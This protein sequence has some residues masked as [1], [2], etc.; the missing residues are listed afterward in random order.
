[1]GSFCEQ[2]LRGSV[3]CGFPLYVAT[4]PPTPNTHT[5]THTNRQAT[6]GQKRIPIFGS[7]HCVSELPK[8]HKPLVQSRSNHPQF[9][10]RS[11]LLQRGGIRVQSK[12][13]SANFI[14]VFNCAHNT[15]PPVSPSL[16]V[17]APSLGNT[18]LACLGSLGKWGR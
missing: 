12:S 9:P 3:N 16:G 2:Q 15:H 18:I 5:H 1:M 17:Q 7:S 8:N 13:S 4:R 10:M 14:M 11:S 6:R